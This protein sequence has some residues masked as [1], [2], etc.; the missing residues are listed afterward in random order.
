MINW[1]LERVDGGWDV[2]DGGW[3][4]E[5]VAC[6]ID[7]MKATDFSGSLV[8]RER[9]GERERLDMDPSLR[10]ELM[11]VSSMQLHVPIASSSSCLIY[12]SAIIPLSHNIILCCPFS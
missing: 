2:E 6:V 7:D 8:Q 12:A 9:S 1:M 5:D 11:A 4:V 3:N 10:S